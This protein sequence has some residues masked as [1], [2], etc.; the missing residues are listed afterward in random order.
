MK[1]KSLVKSPS[2]SSGPLYTRPTR[3]SRRLVSKSLTNNSLQETSPP[4]ESR[5]ERQELHCHACSRYVQFNVDMSLNGNHVLRC[6][7]CD[8]E[9]CRVVR[10]GKITDIR[11][12]QRNGPTFYI[13]NYYIST[14]VVS[15][16]IT[17][18]SNTSI[19]YVQWMNMMSGT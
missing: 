3:R 17:S 13:Q 11:W 7:N 1:S 5:F 4:A 2:Q 9:H 19:C 6:P 10:D 8:H 18:T 16:Y 12:D 14:S 15:T